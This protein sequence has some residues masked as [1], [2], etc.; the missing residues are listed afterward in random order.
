MPYPPF[1]LMSKTKEKDFLKKVTFASDITSLFLTLYLK[2]M[3]D[4]EWH[5]ELPCHAKE[6]FK[7]KDNI[8]VLEHPYNKLICLDYMKHNVEDIEGLMRFITQAGRFM[9]YKIRIILIE[10]N[11]DDFEEL[12]QN[13]SVAK[14]YLYLPQTLQNNSEYDGFIQLNPL[15]DTALLS[16]AQDYIKEYRNQWKIDK[17]LNTVDENEILKVLRSGIHKASE[18]VKTASERYIPKLLFIKTINI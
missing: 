7:S 11:P 16:I 18:R 13:G 6:W 9:E 10:R 5:I 12:L 17:N 3:E 15:E 8:A 1:L 4:S 14:N 2:K